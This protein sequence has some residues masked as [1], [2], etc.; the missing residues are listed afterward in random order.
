MWCTIKASPFS[1]YTITRL[2]PC[3][4]SWLGK[5]IFKQKKLGDNCVLKEARYSIIG[6]NLN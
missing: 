3:V 1:V 4:M 5:K 2:V 6:L